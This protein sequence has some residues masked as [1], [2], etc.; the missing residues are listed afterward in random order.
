MRLRAFWLS[1]LIGCNASYAG[2]FDDEE[3][4][5]QIAAQQALIGDLRNQGR[6]LEARIVKLEETLNDQPLLELHNQIETLRLDMNKLQGQI[7][8]L[9]N[10]NELTQ[11]RQKDF[12][13]DLD[14]RL[15]RLEQPDESA[16]S[17]SPAPPATKS[18]AAPEPSIE[19]PAR[20]VAVIPPPASAAPTDTLESREYEAAYSLF[21]NAKYQDAISQFKQFI[22]SYPGS[23][24]VP[25]AHYWT[26]NAYYA[27]R[28]FKNAISTQEKLIATFPASSKAPDAM[29]N[30]ASSQ[31]EMNQKAAAK[32]TLENL[33]AKYPGSDAAQKAKQRLAS[34]K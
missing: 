2:L 20:V 23:S 27:K 10:E 4:R 24:L 31:Q 1:L 8:V 15:R 32:K 16:A 25:S 18:E 29:L 6:T 9:V 21:K 26:G 7:E 30:I 14:S 34:R 22:K 17:E 5:K 33:I 28:D 13:I 12:Y 11:K 19:T 3:A